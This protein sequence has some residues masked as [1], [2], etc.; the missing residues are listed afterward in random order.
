MAV[1]CF[2][3]NTSSHKYQYSPQFISL[4]CHCPTSTMLLVAAN[5]ISGATGL[6][7][8]SPDPSSFPQICYLEIHIIMLHILLS[9]QFVVGIKM[10]VDKIQNV[11]ENSNTM[12][13]KVVSSLGYTKT[14]QYQLFSLILPK[15]HQQIFDLCLLDSSNL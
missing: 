11:S 14:Q 1:V 12:S 10:P 4:L 5:A 2:M 7:Q 13:S 6:I 9:S 15:Y 3:V 8:G